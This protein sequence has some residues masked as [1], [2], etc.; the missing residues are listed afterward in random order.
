VEREEIEERGERSARPCRDGNSHGL[1]GQLLAHHLATR[2]LATR[3]G[4]ECQHREAAVH[5][6]RAGAH[7]VGAAGGGECEDLG[8]G[9]DAAVR[10]QLKLRICI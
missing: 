10:C 7:E 3:G 9:P 6:L 5:E 4:R 1:A 2:D 8:A